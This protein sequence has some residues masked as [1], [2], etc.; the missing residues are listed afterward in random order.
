M[1]LSEIFTFVVFL[2]KG[3][4][5]Y[6]RLFSGGWKK[7]E[8]ESERERERGFYHECCNSITMTR[9][10]RISNVTN[11]ETWLRLFARPGCRWL[12]DL[13]TVCTREL[14]RTSGVSLDSGS[15][16]EEFNDIVDVHDGHVDAPRVTISLLF[17]CLPG[18]QE[19]LLDTRLYCQ[20]TVLS[21][22]LH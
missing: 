6:K 13:A 20:G 19:S 18:S 11:H 15:R 8:R 22:S 21:L 10:A 16:N 7:E 9:D 12:V 3:E 5:R 17:W 1:H 2:K 14:S 4:C